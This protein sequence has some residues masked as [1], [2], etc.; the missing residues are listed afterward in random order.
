MCTI[1]NKTPHYY[2]MGKQKSCESVCV[3]KLCEHIM[4]SAWRVYTF[5]HRTM[6]LS[7]IPKKGMETPPGGR[8][9]VTAVGCTVFGSLHS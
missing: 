2:I 8:R 1:Y 7:L 3:V 6:F 5:L 4:D 9:T